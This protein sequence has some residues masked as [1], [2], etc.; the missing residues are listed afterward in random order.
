MIDAVRVFIGIGEGPWIKLTFHRLDKGIGLSAF[1]VPPAVDLGV[2]AQHWKHQ[3][4]AIARLAARVAR[5]ATGRETLVL[6]ERAYHGFDPEFTLGP[7]GVPASS[8]AKL[9]R[10][11]WNDAEALARAR[12]DIVRLERFI[13]A[14]HT[15]L[16]N[17]DS[18]RWER[19]IRTWVSSLG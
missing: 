8:L 17:Y 7:A 6:F 2:K 13:M 3:L 18:R 10:V 12:P 14:R 19:A 4:F 16:W 5:V 1:A 15:R 11:P 9:V